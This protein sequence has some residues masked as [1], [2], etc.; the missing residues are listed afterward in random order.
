MRLRRKVFPLGQEADASVFSVVALRLAE[1]S[2]EAA[3]DEPAVL[4]W[5]PEASSALLLWDGEAASPELS[6]L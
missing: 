4:L 6:V 3:S 5:L 2:E 1:A